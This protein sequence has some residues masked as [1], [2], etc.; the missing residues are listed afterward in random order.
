MKIKLNVEDFFNLKS[1]YKKDS[2]DFIEKVKE[3]LKIINKERDIKNFSFF[4][5][6]LFEEILDISPFISEYLN[7]M[8][9][10]IIKK[11]YY[12]ELVKLIPIMEKCVNHDTLQVIEEMLKKPNIVKFIQNVDIYKLKRIIF[13]TSKVKKNKDN[14][15]IKSTLEIEL[16][17]L[18]WR[19]II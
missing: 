2:K 12:S 13:E 3:Y 18:E 9:I 1:L 7:N 16:P 11:N 14:I 4:V 5:E 8:F 19:N 17:E 6:N 10:L 15:F